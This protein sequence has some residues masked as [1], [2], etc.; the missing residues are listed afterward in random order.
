VT[1][2]APAEMDDLERLVEL[3]L[4]LAEGQRAHGS[5]VD[6]EANADTVRES[7]AQHLLTGGVLVARL[8]GDVV[9]FVMF[10]PDTSGFDRARDRGVV[11]NVYVV[12]AARG[13][14][15]GTA[16]MDAAEVRLG[17]EGF[18]EVV[19]EAMADN[20]DARRFYRERGYDPHRIT[21]AKPLGSDTPTR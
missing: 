5:T 9:G 4:D 7:L 16:L 14:G 18:D 17:D 21:L 12:P 3:W 20:D 8:D 13:E 10:G 15:I 1:D 6:P 11:R 2:V 19:L